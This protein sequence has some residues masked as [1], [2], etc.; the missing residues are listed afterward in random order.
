MARRQKQLPLLTQ[1]LDG[2][3]K[4]SAIYV[5]ALFFLT[6]LVIPLISNPILKTFALTLKPVGLILIGIFSL[7]AIYK[8]IKQNNTNPYTHSTNW[9]G[10]NKPSGEL[11][12]DWDKFIP[13]N[14]ENSLDERPAVSRSVEWSLTLIQ[15]I[16]WKKFEELSTAYFQEKGIHA[17]A[18][19]LGADGGIDI[20]LYQDVTGTPSSIIKCK[21]WNHRQVGVKQI[22]EFLVVMTHEKITKGFYMTSGE[23]GDPCIYET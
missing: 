1:A 18:T 19:S 17:E 4:V 9:A 5:A 12:A 13:R 11:N 6:F 15:D 2:N 10:A 21:A 20:K 22:R 3:W 23:R 8:L 14:Q 7:I 16:E